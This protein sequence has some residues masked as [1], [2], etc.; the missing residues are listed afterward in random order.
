VSV[1]RR[2]RRLIELLTPEHVP[3]R[4]ELGEVSARAAALLI[5]VILIMMVVVAIWLVALLILQGTHIAQ[6]VAIIAGFLVRS[7]YFAGLELRL[8]GQTV[9]K[10]ILR[11]QV[12]ARDGGPLTAEMVVARNLTREL[13]LF[14]PLMFLLAPDILGDMPGVAKLGT[15][16]WMGILLVLPAL[17]HHRA[18]VGDLLGGTMVVATPRGTLLRDLIERDRPTGYTFTVAQLDLYGIKELQ[19]LETILRDRLH[20]DVLLADVANRICAKL[21]I[22]DSVQPRAFLEAFYAAQRARLEQKLLMGTRQEEKI[23]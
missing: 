7:F 15:V 1:P 14:V 23:R 4:M 2:D 16:V 12:V 19:V 3:V 21:Q 22:T 9:G 5:D 8:Q 18:R 13:E 20:D 11:L 17:N 6:A 10:K